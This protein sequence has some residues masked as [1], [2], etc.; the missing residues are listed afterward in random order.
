M[1]KYLAILCC[2]YAGYMFAS[3]ENQNV[4]SM[5]ICGKNTPFQE[6]S[7][8]SRCQQEPQFFLNI[9]NEYPTVSFD[10][11][12]TQKLRKILKKDSYVVNTQTFFKDYNQLLDGYHCQIRQ[13]EDDNRCLFLSMVGSAAVGVSTVVGGLLGA[14]AAVSLCD[15]C[16]EESTW[17]ER[18]SGKCTDFFYV[19]GVVLTLIGMVPVAFT[20]IAVLEHKHK[21][22]LKNRLFNQGDEKLIAAYKIVKKIFAADERRKISW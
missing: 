10:P 6:L 17:E 7:W 2:L 8:V 5:T 22:I 19:K 15:S 13:F 1:K 11:R 20:G 18:V 3:G 9:I 12:D 14:T 4:I 16:E 21:K